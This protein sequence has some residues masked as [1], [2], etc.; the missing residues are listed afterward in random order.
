MNLPR[1]Y[2]EHSGWDDCSCCKYESGCLDTTNDL[3]DSISDDSE[4]IGG[5][6]A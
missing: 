4:E 5:E 3:D 1:C 6:E 2:G